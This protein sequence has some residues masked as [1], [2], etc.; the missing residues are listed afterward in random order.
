M[1][2]NTASDMRQKSAAELAKNLTE[3][4]AKLMQT[5]VDY[6]T[7]E[8]KNVK[9]IA[10]IRRD[11]ARAKTIMREQELALESAKSGEKS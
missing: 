11:I 8:V 4:Q 2:V 3:L 5:A 9:L 1:K 10:A 7:K 6:R